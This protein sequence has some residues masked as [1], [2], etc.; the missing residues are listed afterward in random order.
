MSGA[1]ATRETGAVHDAAAARDPRTARGIGMLRGALA[2]AGKDLRAELRSPAQAASLFVF[3]L[4]VVVVFHFAFD[5][6][7]AEFTTLGPG[8]LWAAIL[9]TGVLAL[10][11]GFRVEREGGRLDGLRLAPMAPSALYF[12][13][14]VSVCTVMAA[15][16]LVL[17][18]L[19]AVLFNQPFGGWMARLAPILLLNT[20]GF[21]AVGCLFACI[22]TQ[23]RHGD[24]L[25]PVLLFPASVP[26]ALAAVRATGHVLAGRPLDR[27][28]HWI[29]LSGA[30]DLIF[31][32]AAVLLFDHA[33]D[34]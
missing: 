26:I 13:K 12:G 15:V 8:I 16:E 1:G 5:L 22:T 2:V 9:F 6:T 23:T 31:L 24:L 20:I 18:P 33:L 29:A 10:D 28:A 17:V 30:Y 21:A 4:L 32:A 11:R 27:F 3:A 25:L 34:D 14:V 7:A 19:A